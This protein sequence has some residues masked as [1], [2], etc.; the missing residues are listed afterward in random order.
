MNADRFRQLTLAAA[1][2]LDKGRDPLSHSFLVEH[3]VAYDEALDLA[4]RMALGLRLAADLLEEMSQPG[5][6]GRLAAMRLADTI[7]KAEL[8]EEVNC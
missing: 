2:A 7:A 6:V 1:A 3:D 4:N 8:A 5:P